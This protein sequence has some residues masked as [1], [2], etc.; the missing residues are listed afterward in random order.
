[1]QVSNPNFFF[2]I[3]SPFLVVGRDENLIINFLM[4]YNSLEL[5]KYIVIFV[6]IQNG[7]NHPLGSDARFWSNVDI[8]MK[9]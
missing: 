1:M 2:Y 6:E 7:K 5:L 8:E 9:H 3:L 4:P